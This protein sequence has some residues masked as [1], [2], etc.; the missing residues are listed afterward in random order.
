MIVSFKILQ[1]Y[2]SK[3][4]LNENIY[5][6]NA[7]IYLFNIYLFIKIVRYPVIHSFMVLYQK[8]NVQMKMY[9]YVN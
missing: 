8:Y 1:L 3:K 2:S 7:F 4:V 5:V 6:V 9:Q